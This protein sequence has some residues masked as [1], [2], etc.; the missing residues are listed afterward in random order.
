MGKNDCN[1]NSYVMKTFTLTDMIHVFSPVLPPPKIALYVDR[2]I[3]SIIGSIHVNRIFHVN[4]VNTKCLWFAIKITYGLFASNGLWGR[5]GMPSQLIYVDEFGPDIKG[6][7]GDDTQMDESKAIDNAPAH[8]E[9]QTSVSR[10]LRNQFFQQTV[11]HRQITAVD[12]RK[13][14]VF[15]RIFCCH[16]VVYKHN[17][18][19]YLYH[20]H[21]YWLLFYKII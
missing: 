18:T 14:K 7:E 5:F 2:P 8:Q 9:Q 13:G 19:T 21:K 1:N 10:Q 17:Q 11:H 12:E 3:D 20:L 6:N 4:P 16:E 15:F